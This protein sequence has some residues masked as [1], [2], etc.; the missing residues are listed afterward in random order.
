MALFSSTTTSYVR[1][2]KQEGRNFAVWVSIVLIGLAIVAIAL[3]IGPVG[4]PTV[5]PAP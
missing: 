3:D 1:V 2:P 4:D 5:F